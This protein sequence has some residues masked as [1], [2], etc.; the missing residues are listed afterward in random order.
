MNS[1]RNAACRH[2]ANTI[3]GTDKQAFIFGRRTRTFYIHTR[4]TN[5]RGIGGAAVDA[6]RT[7]GKD[8]R[9]ASPSR[10]RS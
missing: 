9:G 7:R 6:V 3:P 5:L 10:N 8:V 2:A 1:P 4:V